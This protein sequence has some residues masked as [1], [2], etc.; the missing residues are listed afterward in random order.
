[1]KNNHNHSVQYQGSRDPTST[2]D[3]QRRA[4]EKGVIDLVTAGAGGN[5]TQETGSTKRKQEGQEFSTVNG[6]R[7]KTS[8]VETKNLSYYAITLQQKWNQGAFRWVH[9]GKYV[10]DPRVPGDTGG[11][12]NGQ[13]CV[14]KEFK[15]GSVYEESFF[16]T[17]LETVEKTQEIVTAFNSI[18]QFQHGFAGDRKRVMLNRPQV[19]QE[20]YPDSTGRYKKKL[21][22]PMLEGDFLKFNSN[23][24]YAKGFDFMQAL[25][26]YSYSHTGGKHLLCDLQGSHFEDCFVL[27]DPVIMSQDDSKQ[28]GP[29]DLGKEGIDNFFVHHKCNCYC[30]PTWIKPLAPKISSRIP[31]MNSTSMSMTIGSKALDSER[32][33]KLDAILA[34]KPWVKKESH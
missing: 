16:Q 30:E 22:E 31:R 29:T 11:P 17:D 34:S 18:N 3:F 21:V 7:S 25:S 6:K 8:A 10:P 4:R 12:Q 19:W 20:I 28:Y 33:K 1:M 24:G 9:K 2:V 23:S 27:T 5:K 15:T 13:L 26:H 32:Q 14:L